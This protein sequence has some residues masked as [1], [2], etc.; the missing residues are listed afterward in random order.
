VTFTVTQIGSLP[1]KVIPEDSFDVSMTDGT[2]RAKI[3]RQSMA[4]VKGRFSFVVYVNRS[5]SFEKTVCGYEVAEDT[6]DSFNDAE[7]AVSFRIGPEGAAVVGTAAVPMHSPFGPPT[8]LV[9]K[10]KN[11]KVST[12]PLEPVSIGGNVS[13]WLPLDNQLT[14]LKGTIADPS[15]T[16]GCTSC[17]RVAPAVKVSQQLVNPGD[18]INVSFA[19]MANTMQAMWASAM[20]FGPDKSNDVLTLSIPVT[21]EGGTTRPQVFSVPVRFT[22]PLWEMIVAVFLGACLGGGLR[23]MFALP[24]KPSDGNAPADQN[25]GGGLKNFFVGMALALICEVVAVVLFLE[26]NTEVKLIGINLDPT[27]V[28]PAFLLCTF[29]GGGTAVIVAIENAL[30]LGGGK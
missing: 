18:R 24:P 11:G 3:D 22:P 5:A 6:V 21:A 25:T 17:W 26:T 28:V 10:D 15:V 20:Q 29:V 8:A 12:P 23:K 27:Q 4:T 1:Y 30:R 2:Y 7:E 19:L 14:N 13:F 9:Y 16:A